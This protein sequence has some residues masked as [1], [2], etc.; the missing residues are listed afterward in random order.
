[1]RASCLNL[2]FA[3]AFSV[4]SCFVLRAQEVVHALTGVVT[5]VDGASKSIAVQTSVDSRVVFSYANHQQVKVDFD[6]N[7]RSEAIEPD[8]YN[9]VGDHVIVYF[10]GNYDERTVVAIKDLGPVALQVSTGTVI[11]GSRKHHSLKMKTEAGASESYQIA[12]DASIETPEGVIE[13]L[14]FDPARNSH[15]IIKYRGTTE[16]RVAEFVRED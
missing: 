8:V 5:S 16:N 9:K 6:R 4:A 12:Q 7:I 3:A 10:Y 15:V 11:N 2:I 13:G 1:M 14:N